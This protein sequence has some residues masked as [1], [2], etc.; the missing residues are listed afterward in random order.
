VELLH[1]ELQDVFFGGR[2]DDRDLQF[3]K[4]KAMSQLKSRKS[5]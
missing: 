3:Y 4:E 5:A 2:V 1:C